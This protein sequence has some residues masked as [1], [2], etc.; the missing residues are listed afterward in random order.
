M[1]Y[2]YRESLA[3]HAAL[4]R[5]AE[6][7]S[8][9]IETLRNTLAPALDK[10]TGLTPE[11][12]SRLCI[13]AAGSLGRHEAGIRSDLDPFLLYDDETAGSSAKALGKLEE[14][15]V[16]AALIEA[17]RDA[18]FPRFDGDGRYLKIHGLSDLKRSA[19]SPRDDTENTFT[20]RMLFVL[21]SQ[22]IY[23]S[24]LYEQL[25]ASIVGHYF[26]DSTG[27]K[28]FRPLF[29]LNDI[30]RFWRTLCL[31][32]E[33]YR[34]DPNRPWLKK[35]L[36]L[37]YA[38][39]L[40]IFS[41][42]LGLLSGKVADSTAFGELAKLTPLTRLAH[43]LDLVDSRAKFQELFEEALDDYEAF[44]SAKETLLDGSGAPEPALF[45]DGASRFETFF[46]K[47]LTCPG[48][49]QSLFRYV[50]S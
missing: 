11:A 42:V 14:Y 39:R 35:N 22:N 49:D 46:F 4:K 41:T 13:V 24:G 40:T 23:N 25:M 29:L 38:R 47:A 28:N 34:K 20:A 30:L 26:R 43:C 36:N 16:F 48:I 8:R 17:N 10:Q 1:A 2:S 18:K 9:H 7:S 50:I 12:R 3:A 33:E 44:L 19:G 15:E 32:Y 45:A 5:R 27:K 37:K 21:E 6:L 31:N